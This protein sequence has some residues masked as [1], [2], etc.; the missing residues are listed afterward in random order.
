V[1]NYIW[2]GL[3]VSSLLF[4]GFYD[5]RDIRHDTYRNGD[6]LP[7]ELAFPH[8]Y[9]AGARQVPVRIRIDPDRYRDFYDTEAAPADGYGGEIRQTREGVQ[10]RF[11]AAADLP[12]PLATIRGVSASRDDELQGTLVGFEPP[13]AA[14]EAGDEPVAP[15]EVVVHTGVRFEKVRFVKMNAIAAA[16]LDFAET[17]ASIALSLIGVLALFLGLL[18]I[19]EE[20]GIIRSL[21][22]VV[23]P[24]LRPLFPDVPE[25]H[26][27]LGMI[28]LNMT[29]NIFGLG[30]AATPFGIK[31]MEEL[32]T[33]NPTDDTATDPMVMLL[34]INTAS[35]QIVPPVLL[36]ALLGL[37]IN[38]LI[39]AIII[40]TG[41]SLIIAIAAAKL[42]GR[43]PGY[44]ASNPNRA[45]AESPAEGDAS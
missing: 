8:G 33:L 4:A 3:I 10:L 6:A 42:Y 13:A 27:A 29:A 36:L 38:E 32:Q 34:A 28:A 43:L 25:D 40:T 24:I 14:A 15:D 20:A 11:D 31:A 7:V 45:A 1:L 16:A 26:P 41:L 37:Q 22:K 35:V 12:E 19:G 18:K 21:V 23:R 9:D 44:R 17:A 2:A 39:F 5:I 30:N